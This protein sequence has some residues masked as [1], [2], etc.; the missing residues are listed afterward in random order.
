MNYKKEILNE[1]LNINNFT[2]SYKIM[3]F[4]A[5]YKEIINGRKSAKIKKL[6]AKMLATSLYP[7]IYGGLNFGEQ[8][9][10][11]DIVLYLKNNFDIDISEN[12]EIRGKGIPTSIH[13]SLYNEES[14]IAITNFYFS[15]VKINE[16]DSQEV[17]KDI[18]DLGI[19]LSSWDHK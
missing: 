1:I 12:E 2:T 15:T 3:W 6:A 19:K 7:I 17:I 18:E 10:L 4:D 16:E 14:F 13:L 11:K 8:D 5:I 9:K